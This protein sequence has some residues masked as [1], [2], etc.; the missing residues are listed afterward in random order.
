MT[1]YD[2]DIVETVQALK[3]EP[4]VQRALALTKEQLPEIIGTQKELVLIEA[5][6]FHEVICGLSSPL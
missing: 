6:S 3:A 1:E 5:P 4:D 2:H